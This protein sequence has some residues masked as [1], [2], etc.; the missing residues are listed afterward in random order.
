MLAINAHW[1]SSTFEQHRACIEFVEIEGN[2][3]GENLANIVATV[4]E[5]FHISDKVMTITAD[6]A[7]NNDTLHRCLYQKLSR[8]YDKYLAETIIRDGMMKFTQNSQIRCF[9]HILNLVMKTILRSLRASSHKEACDLL[10]DVAKR[11]WGVIKAPTSPI[12][13]L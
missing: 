6:N 7:S 4:L 8:R 10:D 12:A 11:S 1:M 2:H 13:K 5:R 9:A 3:S